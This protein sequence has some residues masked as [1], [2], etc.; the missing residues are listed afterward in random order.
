MKE[1]QFYPAFSEKNIPIV[2]AADTNYFNYLRVCIRSLRYNSPETNL[3]IFILHDDITP[4]MQEEFLRSVI[5]DNMSIRFIDMTKALEKYGISNLKTVS[6][7][8]KAASYRLI[9]SEILTNFDKILYL[10]T[11]IVIEKDISLLYNINLKDNWIAAVRG[12]GYPDYFNWSESRRK[13]CDENCNIPPEE[14]FNSGVL[15]FNCN[16]FRSHNLAPILVEIASKNSFFPDQDALNIACYG[17]VLLLDMTWNVQVNYCWKHLTSENSADYFD[18]LCNASILHYSTSIK[19]WNE[20][21]SYLSERWWKY[22]TP[23]EFRTVFSPYV[24]FDI[25]KNALSSEI[26][27]FFYN[28]VNNFGDSLNRTLIE[29]LTRAKVNRTEIAKSELFAVGSIL[30]DSTNFFDKIA[31]MAGAPELHIWGSGFLRA[32]LPEKPISHSRKFKIHALRGKKTLEVFKAAGFIRPDENIPLGDPGILYP[33]LIEGIHSIP[34]EYDV[35]IIPHWRDKEE[36]MRIAKDLRDTWDIDAHFLDVSML[37]PLDFIRELAKSRKVISSSMHGL[38]VS[39][40]LGIPNKRLIIG[41]FFEDEVRQ[42]DMSFYKFADYYSAF[43]MDSPDYITDAEL[44]EDP[45]S[46]ILSIDDSSR[47]PMHKIEACKK[48]LLEC[49]PYAFA[50]NKVWPKAA[51]VKL[52]VILPSYN[53]EWF[54]NDCLSSLL[55]RTDF[56]DFEVICID[57]GSTDGTL[58]MLRQWEKCDSRVKVV[59][60]NHAG[61]GCARNLGLSI[62]NG[63]YIMFLDSDDRV[64][65]GTI[66]RKAY[67]RAIADDL[68]ILILGSTNISYHGGG[69]NKLAFFDQSKL[70]SSRV[71]SIN[72]VSDQD[73]ALANLA[74]WGKLFKR[75]FIMDN[76]FKFLPIARSEDFPMVH[77]AILKAA[78]IGALG[79]VFIEHR[80]GNPTSLESTKDESPLIFLEAEATLHDEMKKRGLYEQF[81]NYAKYRAIKRFVWNLNKINS[82]KG[83]VIMCSAVNEFIEKYALPEGEDLALRE[84]YINC[85]NELYQISKTEDYVELIFNKAMKN[86][87][88]NI[89][90]TVVNQDILNMKRSM[91]YKFDSLNKE[92]CKHFAWTNKQITILRD[93]GLAQTSS[94]TKEMCK[95]FSWTNKQIAMLRDDGLAQTSSVTKEMCK[96]TSKSISL[97]KKIKNFFGRD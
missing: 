22:V 51:E 45:H 82:F 56:Q 62:A 72:T 46:I 42:F 18:L 28:N 15:I 52:S 41:N 50:K 16:A 55:N 58:S 87:N 13:W 64:A 66:L 3:D 30:G 38:I 68:D 21:T 7:F 35:A 37:N 86:S 71:F 63:K 25:C 74:P 81:G 73:F 9:I 97:I 84:D 43:D 1:Y 8:T 79:E 36:G 96:Q 10:D 40:A 61:P 44:L 26:N 85:I 5:S 23:G 29:K 60:Q 32:E 17:H 6:Y 39:D 91:L 90:S 59:M 53:T 49:F 65:R 14:Y 31:N 67:E 76:G 4:E 92:L 34:K 93:D 95:H 12:I 11:D 57:D 75:S 20:P 77:S 47:V 94:V 48:S 83:Y 2:F 69:D 24:K 33:D 89:I 19:P 80:L 70:P 27:L 78:R 54:I 88:R